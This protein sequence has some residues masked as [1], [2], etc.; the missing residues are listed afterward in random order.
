MGVILTTYE[1]WDDPPFVPEES[2]RMTWSQLRQERVFDTEKGVEQAVKVPGSSGSLEDGSNTPGSTNILL[3][4]QI[5]HSQPPFGMYKT[6]GINYHIN[7]CRISSINSSN[8]KWTRIEDVWTL[9]K[10][11]I[12]QPAML[13]HQ[14]VP[15]LLKRGIF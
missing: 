6:Y 2:T 3:M 1:S 8:G 10:M 4:V 7:W 12:F 13:V 9:L 15:F 5:S 11:G 14:R